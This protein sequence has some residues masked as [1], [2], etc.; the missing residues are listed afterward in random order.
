MPMHVLTKVKCEDRNRIYSSFYIEE[1]VVKITAVAFKTATVLIKGY[2]Q[3]L[4]TKQLQ[5]YATIV[6]LF[7]FFFQK[8]RYSGS[9]MC[10]FSFVCYLE[11]WRSPEI[12]ALTY[13]SNIAI[14]S[15]TP[16]KHLKDVDVT[17]K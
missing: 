4:L 3:M 5:S 17:L 12:F 10:H 2:F 9:L 8:L 13:I 1:A 7:R 6:T 14:F 16:E 15:S 11:F